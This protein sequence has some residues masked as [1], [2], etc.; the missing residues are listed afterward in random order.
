MIQF[1]MST[2][3]FDSY[4]QKYPSHRKQLLNW[5]SGE[6]WVFC[7]KVSFDAKYATALQFWREDT[8]S[9]AEI[10]DNT[11]REEDAVYRTLDILQAEGVIEKIGK[12]EYRNT[13][14][15]EGYLNRLYN[16]TQKNNPDRHP[17]SI[18]VS[19]NNSNVG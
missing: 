11:T 2:L 1:L 7:E 16:V 6:E 9:V 13:G 3:P 10:T 18:D 14:I 4:Y 5:A 17:K 15:T 19:T 8:T 12:G